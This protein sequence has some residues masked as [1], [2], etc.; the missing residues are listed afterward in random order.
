ML[1]GGS[2][3]GGQHNPSQWANLPAWSRRPVVAGAV[4]CALVA[5][6]Y[7]PALWAGFV[8][9]DNIFAESPAV[10]AW[11]GVW[12]IWFSPNEIEREGHYWPI[13]YTTFWLE[14]KLWGLEPFGYHLTNVLL[15][16]ATVLLLWRLLRCL[17]VPGAWAVA[18]VFAL[19]PMHVDSVAWAIGRKDLLSGLCCIACV[20]CWF[21]SIGGAEDGRSLDAFRLP[22][23][24]LYLAALGLVVA[25]M[26][27]KSVAV[28][29]PLAFVILLWWK[30]GRVT[31][32]DGWRIAPFLVVA[33]VIAVADLLY[34]Q[35]GRDFSLDYS[36]LERV[37]IASRALWYYAEKLLWPV[38]LAV[39]APLWDV[40]TGDL[41]TW[42]YLIAAVGVATLLWFGR[43]RLGR[44]PFGGAVFFAI[45]LSPV[46]GFVDYTHMQVSFVADRYAYLP[47][48]GVIAVIVSAAVQGANRVPNLLRVG[49][50]GVLVTVLVIFGKLTW[51]QTGIYR[52]EITFYKH[53]VSLNPRVRSMHRNL[54]KALNDAGRPEEALAAVRIEM[55]LFPGSPMAHN[56]H[57]VVLLALDRLDEAA[58]SFERAIELDP[59]QKNARQNMGET[60]RKQGRFSE[61]TTWYREV[62]DLDPQFAPAHAGMGVALYELGQYGRAVESL[63]QA[64][65][66][67]L[68]TLPID[69]HQFLA[70]ALYK[71]ERHEEAVERYRVVVELDPKEAA[72][73]AG[74]GY[75]LYRLQRY[76]G[77]VESLG[78]SVSLEPES[79]DSVNRHVA[80]GQAYEALGRTEEAAT[81]YLRASEIDSRNVTAL[82]SLA[83]LRFRQQRYEE[84]LDHYETLVDIDDADAQVRVN[85]AAALHYLG[86]PEE[87]LRSLERA[88]S[89]DPALAET[90]LGEIRDALREERE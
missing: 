66:L 79:P 43:H 53:I 16:M 34:Y 29:L 69:A 90:G 62:L 60:R 84:A 23:P 89:L 25:A 65:S 64:V 3:K 44:G 27:S 26:L 7:Y 45:T 2:S 8:L 73:Y 70:E 58:E 31:C 21:R 47:G 86:R 15:Y 77:A 6:C 33:L 46:L 18:A 19:H 36:F 42:S 80:M 87:A 10:L 12:D 30:N 55:K 39:V 75:A 81:Q 68:G 71:Q 9:D 24:G 48:I 50:L 63:Q 54:A 51:E 67:K 56:T 49:A 13:T 14:H 17:A 38:D 52:D 1:T 85:M 4:L 83:W 28:T 41:L 20:L 61:S 74:I 72:A 11:S 35:S 82:N 76:E 32:A 88:M 5:V 78:R 59:N 37:L 40:D 22:R 57:G